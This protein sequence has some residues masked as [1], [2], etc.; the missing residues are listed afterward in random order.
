M[1]GEFEYILFVHRKNLTSF[2]RKSKEFWNV[3]EKVKTV[4]K[5]TNENESKEYN[6]KTTA[7]VFSCNLIL[8]I[9][10]TLMNERVDKLQNTIVF[11]QDTK[12]IKK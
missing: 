7:I 6:R 9:V 4:N 3:T 10:F 11:L 8:G 5:L 1:V 2:V 12:P